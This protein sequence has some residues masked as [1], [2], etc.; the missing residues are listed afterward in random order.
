MKK[1]VAVIGNGFVGGSLTT[2]F[3]ERGFDVYVA[4]KSG[5]TAPGGKAIAGL[6]V[7]ARELVTAI[8][9]GR[10]QFGSDVFEHPEW[11]Q[12][13]SGIYFVCVPTPMHE[14]GSADLS[15][16]ESV[17]EELAS[18]SGERIA[19]VKSTVP[20]GSTEAWNKRF[21]KEGL[22]I[23]FNPEF[24]RENSALDDMRNQDRIILG[25]PKKAVNK[26]KQVFQAAYPT[27]PIIKTSSTNAEL[28]KYFTNCI[29]SM[30]ISFANEMYMLCQALDN[31][32]LNVDYDRVV[33]CAILDKRLGT[34]H[35][36]VP[37]FE[38]DDQG[39]PLMGF[40]LS[41]FPKDLNALIHKE[42]ELGLNPTMLEA[43]WQKNLEVRPSRDWEKLLGRAVSRK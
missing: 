42:K 36:K 6:R 31:Q 40:S 9:T 4:D 33:E 17:L 19:V 14:D 27:V 37:S 21:N 18:V 35:W 3:A 30:K 41:C 28:T 26:I 34:S 24:L 15:I 2:V 7:G 32:G 23:V 5:R 13:F 22:H 16:V 38:I 43:T 8:E 25:G 12:N 20:P 10:V 1:S 29:L 39:N 11:A